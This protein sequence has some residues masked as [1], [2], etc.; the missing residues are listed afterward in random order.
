MEGRA[1]VCARGAKSKK[2]FGSLGDRF[3]EDLDLQVTVSGMELRLV[4]GMQGIKEQT[5][6]L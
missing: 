4:S 1:V 2:V 3:A 5:L 6:V